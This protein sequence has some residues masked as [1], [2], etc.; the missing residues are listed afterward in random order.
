VLC[1]KSKGKKDKYDIYDLE[2]NI[3]THEMRSYI[4]KVSSAQLE[5]IKTMTLV[6]TIEQLVQESTFVVSIS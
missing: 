5:T 1:Q 2:P 4:H 6:R 3:I